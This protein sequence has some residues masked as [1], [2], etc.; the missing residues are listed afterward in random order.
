MRLMPIGRTG[1]GKSSV[2]NTILGSSA[3]AVSTGA[4]GST[5][6]ECGV[7]MVVRK[8]KRIRVLDTCGMFDTTRPHEEVYAEIKKSHL[9][10]TPGP[11]A[12]LLVVPV[13]PFTKEHQETVSLLEGIFP[14]FYSHTILVFSKA[15]ALG[16]DARKRDIQ[17]RENLQSMKELK[18]LVDKVSG[19]YVLL[20]NKEKDAGLLDDQVHHL[21]DMVH[22]LY[23]ANQQHHYHSD[24]FRQAEEAA[25]KGQTVIIKEA[26]IS[27]S[28]A[29]NTKSAL[30]HLLSLRVGSDFFRRSIRDASIE[31]ASRLAFV[32]DVEAGR[33]KNLLKTLSFTALTSVL[34]KKQSSTGSVYLPSR[35]GECVRDSA[36]LKSSVDLNNP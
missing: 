13:E 6:K 33:T 27:N 25:T 18:T 3:F 17:L 2:G 32:K 21:L 7:D 10:I 19:R 14:G 35:T 9:M 26:E 5:T 8:G 23:E 11:H 30:Q 28:G 31:N 24:A 34:P 4:F 29:Q 12:F 15:D 20:D 1:S 36:D 22:D 16:D